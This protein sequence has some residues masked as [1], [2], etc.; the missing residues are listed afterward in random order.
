MYIIYDA[1]CVFVF[2]FVNLIDFFSMQKVHFEDVMVPVE[3]LLGG[4]YSVYTHSH[5][6]FR[7][8]LSLKLSLSLP[9]SHT[10]PAWRY[11]IYTHTHFLSPLSLSNSLYLYLPLSHT[12][13]LVSLTTV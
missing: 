2:V 9:L 8:F 4:M 3:N 7:F 6:F 12:H 11:S 5:T 1:L 10:L 13:T